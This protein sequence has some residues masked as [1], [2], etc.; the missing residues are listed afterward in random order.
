[1]GDEIERKFLVTGD[2][3]RVGRST[4]YVQG[5]LSRD[6]GRTVRVRQAGEKAF[7]TVK[8]AA[9]GVSRKEFEYAI[10][11]ADAEAMFQLC[12][13]PLIEKTRTVVEFEGKKWEVDEFHGDNAGLVVAEIELRSEDEQ[14]VSPPWVGREVSSDRRYFNSSLTQHPYKDWKDTGA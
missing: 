2:G 5:Y 13:G 12:V 11:V 3:W 10:P 4:K 8:G 6:P 14:F 9:T 7:I 1:M